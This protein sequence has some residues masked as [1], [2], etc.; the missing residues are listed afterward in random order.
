MSWL[1]TEHV[2][3]IKTRVSRRKKPHI[4]TLNGAT[5]VAYWGVGNYGNTGLQS[6]PIE[7]F[8][9]SEQQQ[10]PKRKVYK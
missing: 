8:T 7:N 2:E 9:W 4:Y 5:R 1:T 10:I 6:C 3:R